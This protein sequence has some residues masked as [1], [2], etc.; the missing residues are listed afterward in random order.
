DTKPAPILSPA[1]RQLAADAGVEVRQLSGSGREGR[2]LKEDVLNYIE[3]Q[4]PA[5]PPP[6]RR[7]ETPRTPSERETRERMS[8]IRQRIATR[9]VEAQSTAAILTTF[10]EIDMS[11]VMALRAKYKEP[12]QKKHGVGLGFMSFFV[13]ACVEALK[14]YP[15]VNARIEGSEIVYQ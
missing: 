7:V 2:I 4:K 6:P 12:F 8:P 11:A 13:R 3:Q 14:A 5:P 9:L 1:A 10:N 15:L